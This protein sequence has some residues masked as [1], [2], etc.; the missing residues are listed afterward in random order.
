MALD[1]ARLKRRNHAIRDV[2]RKAIQYIY[3]HCKSTVPDE[4]TR[5]YV[6]SAVNILRP[7]QIPLSPAMAQGL[8]E[9]GWGAQNILFGIKARNID[10]AN[11]K[12]EKRWTREYIDGKWIRTEAIFFRDHSMRGEFEQ[13]LDLVRRVHPNFAENYPAKGEE[14]LDYILRD[15]GHKAYAT[16]PKYKQKVLAIVKAAGLEIFDR[17]EMYG[18]RG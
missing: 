9:S 11:G 8:L 17:F 15:P 6:D 3:D 13:Y 14:Y 18:K 4:W 12:A 1:F 7:A 16:D 5:E 2:H 10:V